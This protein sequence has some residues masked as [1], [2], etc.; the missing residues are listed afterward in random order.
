MPPRVIRALDCFRGSKLTNFEPFLLTKN[1]K[2]GKPS[3]FGEV[4]KFAEKMDS[5]DSLEP[6]KGKSENDVV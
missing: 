3:K 1:V 5:K 6:P 2:R 4:A